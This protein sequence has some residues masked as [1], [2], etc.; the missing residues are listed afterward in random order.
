MK[1]ADIVNILETIADPT[2]AEDWD[3]VGLLVGDFAD[4]AGKLMLCIDLTE[5]VLAEAVRRKAKMVMAYHSVIFKPASRI[6]A[7]AQPVVLEA[8]RKGIAVYSMHTALD[9]AEGGTND[10]LA[11]AM[12]LKEYR[13]IEPAAARKQ[14]KIVVCCP[15]DDVAGVS[16]AAFAAGGGIIGD[17]RDCA[18]ASAGTG[19]FC[20]G[21]GTSPTIGT[22]GVHEIVDEIRLEMVCPTSAAAAVCAAIAA[23][24]SYE[25]PAIDVY[26]VDAHATGLGMGRVGSFARPVSVSTLIS[27]IKK[28]TGVSKVLLAGPRQKPAAIKTRRISVAAC[29]AGACGSMWKDAAACGAEFFLTGEMRHHEALAAAASGVTVV[30][31][32]HSN[33]ERMTLHRL[34]DR[35]SQMCDKLDVFVSATDRD[36]F[37]IV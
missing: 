26:H 4:S 11:D 14:S 18:F 6:T 9:A 2:L 10:V 28:H 17:Y 21:A 37:D 13:P 34:A 1:V 24:H 3:N 12:G 27:R 31:V 36:P 25:E 19:M 35:I 8:I 22:R 29:V 23:A 16:S 15:V 33:S 32:G 5:Q 7:S 30:C 20:A